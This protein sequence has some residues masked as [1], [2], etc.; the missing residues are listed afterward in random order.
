ML[1]QVFVVAGLQR[2]VLVLHRHGEEQADEIVGGQQLRI[3]LGRDGVGSGHTAYV[4]AKGRSNTSQRA[5]AE[6]VVNLR[7]KLY[8]RGIGAW[9]A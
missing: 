2:V 1:V 8:L 4:E 5:L 6:T 9:Y 7:R 3:E